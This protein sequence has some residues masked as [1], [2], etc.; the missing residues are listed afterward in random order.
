VPVLSVLY[1]QT[2]CAISLRA[3]RR[4]VQDTSLEV[5]PSLR[6]AGRATLSD[7]C[8]PRCIQVLQPAVA[9]AAGQ[10]AY[11]ADRITS[12]AIMPVAQAVADQVQFP[13]RIHYAPALSHPLPPSMRH[14][15]WSSRT[16]TI[17]GRC[18]CN[19]A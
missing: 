7:T 9:D 10:A 11:A 14:I 18:K 15:T 17:Y 2:A 16:F 8:S 5:F 19:V 13:S 4:I 3:L 1:Q 12:E 6:C